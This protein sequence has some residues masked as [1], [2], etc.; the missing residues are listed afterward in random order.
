MPQHIL[1]VDDEPP[2][3][4]LVQKIL[5]SAGYRVSAAGDGMG[6][7]KVV[8]EDPPDAVICDLSMPGID[9]YTVCTMIKRQKTLK[10]PVIVLSARSKEKDIADALKTGAEAFMGKPVSRE[11]L[12]T[13]LSELLASR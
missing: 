11:A 9:G 8:R 1:V 10:A 5:E 12:L 2:I 4:L 7:L 13:K 3:R 6:A